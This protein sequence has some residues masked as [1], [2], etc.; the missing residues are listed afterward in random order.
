MKTTTAIALAVLALGAAAPQAIA[1]NSL[2]GKVMKEH[3]GEQGGTTANPTAKPGDNSVSGKVMKELPANTKGSTSE[4][5]AK[6]KDN[7]LS[8]KEMERVQ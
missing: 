4:P 5:T 3:P 1:D 6:P 8:G 7:S 2:S